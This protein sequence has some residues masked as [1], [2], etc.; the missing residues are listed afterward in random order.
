MAV[1]NIEDIMNSSLGEVSSQ[2]RASF[3][4]TVLVRQYETEVIELESTVN[5]DKPITSAERMLISAMLQIQLEYDAYCQLAFK[6]YV[7]TS[8]FNQHKGVLLESFNALKTKLE[9]STGIDLS[10]YIGINLK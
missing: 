9:E 2:I 10:S 7:T 3:K 4:K 5:I 1:I 8:E 6:G